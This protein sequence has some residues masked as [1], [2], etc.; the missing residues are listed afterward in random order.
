MAINKTIEQIRE[1]V[2]RIKNETVAKAN[3]AT[4]VG[5]TL[6][7]IVDYIEEAVEGVLDDVQDVV[8]GVQSSLSSEV[9]RA[10][11]KE[12]ELESKVDEQS[13]AI[14]E[15]IG[16]TTTRT[17]TIAE[18]SKLVYKNS[19]IGTSEVY[20]I[21]KAVALRSGETL[22]ASCVSSANA[23][24]IAEEIEEGISYVAL[25]I[26]ESPLVEGSYTYTASRDMNVAISYV[27]AKPLSVLVTTAGM[28]K[29]IS[30]SVNSVTEQL[31]DKFGELE[32]IEVES[33]D[34]HFI[35]SAGAYG[36]NANYSI[37][38]SIRLNPGSILKVNCAASAAVAVFAKVVG[39]TYT[40]LLLGESYTEVKEYSYSATEEIDVVITYVKAKPITVLFNSG[41]EIAERIGDSESALRDYV[42]SVTLIT[43]TIE[44]GAGKMFTDLN[45]AIN[46]ITDSS[47]NNQYL[48]LLYE[49]TY[50]TVELS[51]YAS[52]YK[53]LIIPDY[54]SIKGVGN[55]DNIIIKGE[56]P[57][58]GYSEYANVVSTINLTMN[59]TVENVTIK[60][61]NI[62]YCNHDDG[63]TFGMIPAKHTFRYVKFVVELNTSGYNVADTCVG[64]GSQVDKE[65]VFEAC[66]FINNNSN[67]S[68]LY[69]HDN[70]SS[71]QKRG[72]RLIVRNCTFKVEGVDLGLS[73]SGGTMP[74]YA[75]IEGNHFSHG[76]YVSTS[77]S[78]Q[79]N[80]WEAVICGNKN[81]S[82]VKKGNLVDVD[83]SEQI[84][85][86]C[87]D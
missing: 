60:S 13:S 37:T 24:V 73:N 36:S 47:E 53:G 78:V 30:D 42:D 70:A 84:L 71:S 10:Q 61:K 59:G 1:E 62:R 38:E 56:L 40:P 35:S 11:A 23:A 76:V 2:L 3:T 16:G 9:G 39:S 52:D 43:H 55:R 49:G 74:C 5:G 81:C 6:E 82:I 68:A 25:V 12:A 48:I 27:K 17:T 31:A 46:S 14:A 4:R 29:E 67:K 20:A 45:S 50:N 63:S 15:C 28:I 75:I 72:G 26:G 19:V 87:N 44:V 65:A 69:E 85:A 57:D 21:T 33:E 18:D 54:V 34:G 79:T 7:D 58:T 64:I 51:K 32:E 8:D 86:Y 41:G 22:T 77:G 83:I 80:K 66:V